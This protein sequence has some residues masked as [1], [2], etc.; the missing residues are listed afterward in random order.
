MTGKVIEIQS[1]GKRLCEEFKEVGK[2]LQ[3][4]LQQLQ[5]LSEIRVEENFD[6]GE[7]EYEEGG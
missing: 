1:N 3:Y 2:Q 4:T 7:E 6:E 5:K